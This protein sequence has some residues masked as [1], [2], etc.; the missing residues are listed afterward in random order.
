MSQVV[1]AAPVRPVEIKN[2]KYVENQNKVAEMLLK[3]GQTNLTKIAR[4]TGLP[5]AEVVIMV[6]EIKAGMRSMD[7]YKEMARERLSQM[8][9]HYELLIQEA[10]EAVEELKSDP[11]TM[12]K[13]PGALKIIGDLEAKRQESLQKAGLYDD[14]ELA[15]MMVETERKVEG[16]KKLLQDIIRSHPDLKEFIIQGLRKIENSD[17]LPEPTEVK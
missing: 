16:I 3:Y 6:D 2:A 12:D 14:S 5:R 13:V 11:K 7:N 10:W 1:R 15:D 17:E 4:A 9:R 8:D